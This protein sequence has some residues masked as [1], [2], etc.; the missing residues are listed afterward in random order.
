[1][2]IEKK[3]KSWGQFW[4][5]QLN[6]TANLAHLAHAPRILILSIAMGANYSFELNS[7]ETPWGPQFFGHNNSF[8]GFRI[9]KSGHQDLLVTELPDSQ[10]CVRYNLF[11][12]KFGCYSTRITHA[13]NKPTA[14]HLY[15]L[16]HTQFLLL[17]KYP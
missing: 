12:Q 3:S 17:T 8:L 9:A 4:T 14:V 7:I 6:S 13:A 10:N 5:Y 11:P 16:L 1:M 15:P 2:A